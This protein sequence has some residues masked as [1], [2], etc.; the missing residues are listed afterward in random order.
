[1]PPPDTRPWRMALWRTPLAVLLA[2]LLALGVFAGAEWTY[3]RALTSLS[4]LGARDTARADLKT[5]MRR[6]LD[7]ETAQRGYLL[8]GREQYLAPY[9]SARTDLDN[10]FGRL[11]QYFRLDGELTR[12]V[13]ELE[14]KALQRVSEVEETISLYKAGSHPAWQGLVLT[15]IGREQMDQVRQVAEVL[16]A[17]EDRRVARE[18]AAVYRTLEIGR[19]SVHGLTL[20]S[21]LA[22]VFFLSKN[23]ALQSSQVAHSRQLQSERDSLERQVRQ[24]TEELTLL[25]LGLQEL[26]EGERGGLARALHDELGA[27]L[28]AAKLDLTR[29]RHALSAP[30][31]D[32]SG[33]LQHLGAMLDQSIDTKRRLMEGLV[34]SALQNLGLQAALEQRAGELQRRTGMAVELDL[35]PLELQASTRQALFAVAQGALVNVEQHAGANRVS[36]RLSEEQGEV[37]L[38]VADNGR[39]FVD[40]ADTGSASAQGL[41]NMR[42]RIESLGGRFTLRS[43]PGDGTHIDVRLPTRGADP[44]PDSASAGPP[45]VSA[46]DQDVD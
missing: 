5:V 17:N 44:E 1:M 23:A 14:E 43:A 37:V 16:L 36:L 30:G 25:N 4:N 2:A 41:K 39:G 22:Y 13:A 19:L 40:R 18:R 8:T 12:L 21:L 6:L 33:R 42:Y 27:L 24:R 7:M 10:A 11:R 35:Q 34:P 20:L 46:H 15:D 26:R 29:L 3:Q 9:A 32:V 38:A 45:E 31:A 28:T